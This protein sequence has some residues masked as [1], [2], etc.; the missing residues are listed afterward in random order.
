MEHMTPPPA[1]LGELR[2]RV[3]RMQGS[4]VRRRLDLLPGLAGVVQLRTGGTYVVDSPSLALALMA[5]PSQAGEWSAVVGVADLGLESAAE[6]GLDLE[7]TVVVP[8]PGE[9]WLSVT[10]GL[11]EVASLVLVRPPTPPSEAQAERLRARLRQKD[12][13]LIALGDWPRAETRI[14]IAESHWVGLGSGHGRISARQVVVEVRESAGRSRRAPL[15]LPGPD[16]SVTGRVESVRPS[17]IA[18][19]G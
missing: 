11:V 10:A 17:V 18:E 12:A 16:L 8:R 4:S 1:T 6:F 2:Q 9:H 13:A 3:H 14:S 5:G 7:R 15:W 19:A